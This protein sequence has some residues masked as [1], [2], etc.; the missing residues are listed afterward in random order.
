[1]NNN[2]D[3]LKLYFKELFFSSKLVAFCNGLTLNRNH[4][5]SSKCVKNSSLLPLKLCAQKKFGNTCM[6]SQIKIIIVFIMYD[7]KLPALV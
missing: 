5:D 3:L 4:P 1:M 7:D 2:K 6:S